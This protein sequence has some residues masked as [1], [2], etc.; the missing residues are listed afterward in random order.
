MQ[1]LPVLPLLLLIMLVFRWIHMAL[2]V[3]VLLILLNSLNLNLVLSGIFYY[4]VV[5]VA[6]IRLTIILEVTFLPLCVVQTRVELHYLYRWNIRDIGYV[7]LITNLEIR[8]CL[9]LVQSHLN[10][11]YLKISYVIETLK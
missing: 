3:P 9:F 4:S 11:L 5:T 1:V 7:S 2:D 10:W 8:S 6:S